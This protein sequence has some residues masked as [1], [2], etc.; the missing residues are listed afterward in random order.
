MLTYQN[1]IINYHGKINIGWTHFGAS[2]SF[3]EIDLILFGIS[4]LD[5]LRLFNTVELTL[6]FSS[7]TND[8]ERLL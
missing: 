5:F 8:F 1:K 3:A 4:F 7:I 2:F 6:L